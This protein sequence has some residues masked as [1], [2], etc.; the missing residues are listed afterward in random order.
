MIESGE[1]EQLEKE[2][3]DGIE[4]G[5]KANCSDLE[6]KGK[7]NTS[8]GLLPYLGLFSICST[9]AILGLSCYMICWLVKNVE[10]L[11]SHTVLTLTQVWR[12]WRWT[13]NIF[14]RCCS[15][16]QSRIMRRVSSCTETRNAEE[17]V[18]NSQQIPVVVELVDTVLAAHAS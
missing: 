17:N 8:I 15:K 11:T 3:L 6:S 10:T 18:T 12:I 2:M 7:N 13:T 5:R 14:G 1:T 4:N 16:L 9:I